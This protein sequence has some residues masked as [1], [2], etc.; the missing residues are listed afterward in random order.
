M[1]ENKE[2]LLHW[3]DEKEVISSNKP[4]KFLLLL[5]SFL[6]GFLVHCVA[7]PVAFFYLLCSKRARNECCLYQKNLREFSKGEVPKIISPYRQILSFSHCVL[8]KLQGWLGKQKYDMVITHDDDLGEL[9]SSLNDGKG[10]LMIG[11]HLGNMELLRGLSSFGENACGR[12]LSVTTIMEMKATEQFNQTLKEINPNAGFNVIDPSDIGPDTICTL[13]EQIEKGG[14]VVVAADRTSA[15]SR[16]KCLTESFL[17]K[18]ANFPYGVFLIAML[19]KAP[20]YYCFGLR[21]K[22]SSLNPKYHMFIEKSSVNLEVGRSERENSIKMLCREFISKLEK[23]C[24]QFP[25]QWYNFYNFWL[26]SKEAE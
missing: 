6:P 1:E 7:F 3:A 22:T 21:S 17:G 10:A 2:E 8:E 15:R 23:F 24:I 13:Q 4:L 19:L 25:Y 11:S 5:F 18:P 9:V 14:L 20:V 12:Q 26:L 16:T